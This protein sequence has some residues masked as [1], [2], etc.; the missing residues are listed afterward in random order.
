MN[1]NTIFHMAIFR[2]MMS[3]SAKSLA[4]FVFLCGGSL[5]MAAPSAWAFGCQA[6]E[7]IALIAEK[8]LSPH[9]LAMVQQLLKDNPTDPTLNTYC[10]QP[11]LDPMAYSSIWADDYRA[12]HRET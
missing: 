7:I 2:R 12:Q 9:A 8:H 6:H 11:D 5:L 1:P 4:V 3:R 10:Q